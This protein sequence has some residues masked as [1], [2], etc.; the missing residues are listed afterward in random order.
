MA[1]IMDR[2]E[3]SPSLVA[4]SRSATSTAR[5]NVGSGERQLSLIA[6]AAA[7]V[8][9]LARR[10]PRGLLLS[11]IGSGMIYRGAT[12]YCGLYASLGVD[13]AT[14]I[15]KS[16]GNWS[17]VTIARSFL[18]DRSPADLYAFWRDFE[19]L[20]AIMSHLK[21]VSVLDDR[22]S[23]WTVNAPTVAGGSVT[24]DAEIIEDRPNER[25]SW[26]SL[27]SSDVQNDGSVEFRRASRKPWYGS[28]SS[29]AICPAS[30][31]SGQIG[32]ENLRN[33]P[34]VTNSR[35]SAHLNARW[36]SV[37][38]SRQMASHVALVRSASVDW[39]TDP[40]RF[41]VA[42]LKGRTMKAAGLVCA[43]QGEC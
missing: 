7:V 20:P 5:T 29:N 26:A 25:I 10:D 32:D 4:T 6:G 3:H 19:N 40:F 8:V 42:N 24:W 22:R 35:G 39:C 43:L 36:K 23:R 37:T 41:K 21:S 17:G 33:Q 28:P 30:R 11:A 38:L 18:V 16:R 2:P 34:G 27:P 12:G 13:T 31:N 1:I 15:K 14:S 9:G